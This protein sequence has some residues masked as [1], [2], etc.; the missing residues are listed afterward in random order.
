MAISRAIK[1]ELVVNGQPLPEYSQPQ[2][3]LSPQKTIKY[4]VVTQGAAFGIRASVLNDAPLESDDVS[5]AI[6]LRTTR[7]PLCSNL[8][9]YEELERCALGKSHDFRHAYV[10][11]EICGDVKFKHFRFSTMHSV[12]SNPGVSLS[13]KKPYRIAGPTY[14]RAGTSIT[15]EY[16]EQDTPFAMF[17]F[18]YS[19]NSAPTISTSSG[20]E[21]LP[22]ETLS[23][24]DL[25]ALAQSLY[26]SFEPPSSTI[27]SSAKPRSK[28]RVTTLGDLMRTTARDQ[29]KVISLFE[30]K[31]GLL[32]AAKSPTD[33]CHENSTAPP[34]PITE[35][36]SSGE[37]SSGAVVDGKVDQQGKDKELAS[38]TAGPAKGIQVR[39]EAASKDPS[40][41]VTKLSSSIATSSEVALGAKVGAQAKLENFIAPCGEPR[42]I[43]SE[44]VLG[45]MTKGG[46]C[47]EETEVASTA[48][49]T[50]C[51]KGMEGSEEEDEGWE[52]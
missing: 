18:R 38:E 32:E 5:Y 27:T 48:T 10:P 37:P 13:T 22:L 6:T 12:I 45:E 26:V 50:K 24:Q 4:V 51:A 9:S 28:G 34:E 44:A 14:R 15:C 33:P 49:E 3:G 7:K 40:E 21:N 17:E 46:K 29:Q 47:D 39:S 31:N 8:F 42:A 2:D 36:S 25:S 20:I 16:L 19:M 30:S 43:G 35:P 23:L 52:L 1:V 41:P 11:D